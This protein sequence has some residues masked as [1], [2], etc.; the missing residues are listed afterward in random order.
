MRSRGPARSDGDEL[1]AGP[2]ALVSGGGVLL[3]LA[4]L[5][6]GVGPLLVA[7]A[8]F[9]LL[10]ALVPAWVVVTARSAV[11]LRRLDT[12]RVIEDEPLELR[13]IVRRGPCG[14]PGAHVLEPVA[15]ARIPVGRPLS[16][17]SGSRRVELRVITRLRRRGR[18]RFEEPALLVSDALS[19]AQLRKT[20]AADGGPDEVLVL[21]RTEPVRWRRA[22]HPTKVLGQFASSTA[23]PTGAGEI[24]GLRPYVPGSSASRIHWPAL[25]RGA[26]LLERRLV[27][28]PHAQPLVVLDARQNRS[29]D[30]DEL[31]DAAVRAT[32]SIAL[33]L[34]R[35][36]GCSV[37]LPGMRSPVAL[38]RELA[39]WPALHTRLALVQG[40]AA[41]VPS[42][43][44]AGV[45][46][47]LVYVAARLQEPPQLPAGAG[48]ASA[49]VLVVPAVLA[50]RLEKPASFEVSGCA[51]F[52]LG[53]SAARRR[54]AA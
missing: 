39:A 19:L 35:S 33:E 47:P 12:P 25:A 52:E 2:A 54:R 37:L 30:A 8:G 44:T 24:D 31:L 7:G 4:G 17:L 36:G 5:M 21:P 38:S 1:K 46:G 53:G 13:L 6:F 22:D 49:F 34:A 48:L 18:Y 32:G 51:G 40:G 42:L 3:V 14:L 50:G 16:L 26:G 11:V 27:S 9:V 10:G 45:K 29:P 41:Q 23:E 15:D 28:E 43:R 20:A